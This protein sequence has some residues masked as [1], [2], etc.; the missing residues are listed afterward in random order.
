VLMTIA[1]VRSSEGKIPI[2]RLERGSATLIECRNA[3]A[4]LRHIG[5][6]GP[7]TVLPD[8]A[9]VRAVVTPGEGGWVEVLDALGTLCQEPWRLGAEA[10]ARLIGDTC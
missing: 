10:A 9:F 2:R 8:D 4:F 5:A 1:F 3:T 6:I 7:D